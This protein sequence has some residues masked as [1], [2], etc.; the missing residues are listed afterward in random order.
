MMIFGMRRC[1]WIVISCA[2]NLIAPA[3]LVT[4]VEGDPGSGESIAIN[5]LTIRTTCISTIDC[6]PQ[7]VF[8]WCASPNRHLHDAQSFVSAFWE[9]NGCEGSVSLGRTDCDAG[10]VPCA[11]RGLVEIIEP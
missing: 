7:L 8:E 4:D 11:H 9:A 6:A 1:Y 10:G 3:C 5:G 2:I